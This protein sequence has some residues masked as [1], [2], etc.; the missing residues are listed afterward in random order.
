MKRLDPPRTPSR[1]PV[2]PDR[3][4][5][6]RGVPIVAMN[7]PSQETALLGGAGVDE[8]I[9]TSFEGGQLSARIEQRRVAPQMQASGGHAQPGQVLD[10]AVFA[11]LADLLGAAGLKK[12]LGQMAEQLRSLADCDALRDDSPTLA[13]EAHKLV[14]SAGMLGFSGLS[15]VC[16]ELE[17]ACMAG[18]GTEQLLQRLKHDRAAALAKLVALLAA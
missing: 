13:K 4:R 14:S 3:E 8:H 6:A 1:Y 18:H 10:E 16:R 2:A 17:A 11:E 5:P 12:L 7:A 15:D 9:G